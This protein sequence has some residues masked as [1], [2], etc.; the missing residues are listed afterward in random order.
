MLAGTCYGMLPTCTGKNYEVN[1]GQKFLIL[2]EML[3]F[4]I[5]SGVTTSNDFLVLQILNYE[6]S[7]QRF[8]I[9]I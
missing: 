8:E 9:S 4:F 7:L 5:F 6:I 1:N 3:R 2:H